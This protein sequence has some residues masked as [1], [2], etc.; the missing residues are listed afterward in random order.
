MK[1]RSITP[2]LQALLD[3]VIDSTPQCPVEGDKAPPDKFYKWQLWL[4]GRVFIEAAL[5]T[6]SELK[7]GRP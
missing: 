1:L 4:R 2:L 3:E 6:F 5:K 7:E